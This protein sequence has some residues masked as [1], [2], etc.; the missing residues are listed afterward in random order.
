MLLRSGGGV[1]RVLVSG[2]NAHSFVDTTTKSGVV[3]GYVAVI[4][5]AP[6]SSN[7]AHSN[8]VS[9]TG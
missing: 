1:G 3:Y 6:G 5:G 2:S 4:P 8:S 7:L 9:I